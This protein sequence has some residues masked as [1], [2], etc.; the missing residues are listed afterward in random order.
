MVPVT[1]PADTGTMRGRKSCVGAASRLQP[2]DQREQLDVVPE[3]PR[4]RILFFI[5]T[6]GLCGGKWL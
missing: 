3:V 5:L 6:H 1:R 2:L 4:T